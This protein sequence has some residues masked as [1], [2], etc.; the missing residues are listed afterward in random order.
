[1]GIP[2]F[3]SLFIRNIPGSVTEF[4]PDNLYGISIDCNGLIHR[5]AGEVFGYGRKSDGSNFSEHESLAINVLF[6]SN[7]SLLESKF[8]SRLDEALTQIF[9]ETIHVSTYLILSVDGVAP[10]AKI[11]QQR[12]RRFNSGKIRYESLKGSIPSKFDTAQITAGTPFMEKINLAITAWFHRNIPKLPKYSIYSSH[13]VPGEGEHK[14]FTILEKLKSL[15]PQETGITEEQFIDKNHCIY[16]LDA[17]LCFLTAMRPYNYYWIRESINLTVIR[18]IVVIQKVKDFIISRMSVETADLAYPIRYIYDFILLGFFIGDDFV[19]GMITLDLN[20]AITLLELQLQYKNFFTQEYQ[21]TRQQSFLIDYDSFGNFGQINWPLFSQ[22]ISSLDQIERNFFQEKV[23]NQKREATSSNYK[24]RNENHKN[25]NY[26]PSVFLELDYDN[27]LDN[28]IHIMTGPALTSVYE[29]LINQKQ[30]N[31]I[32]VY[33]NKILGIMK[34]YS[35]QDLDFIVP[36]YLTGLQWNI[37][38]YF[39]FKINN[40][41]YRNSLSPCIGHLIRYFRKNPQILPTIQSVVETYDQPKISSVV[42]LFSVLHPEYNAD[43][44]RQCKLPTYTY[45][46]AGLK[47]KD[48]TF[49]IYFPQEFLVIQEGKY[50]NQHTKVVVLSRL[51]LPKLLTIKSNV[52]IAEEMFFEGRLIKNTKENDSE[53]VESKVKFSENNPVKIIPSRPEKHIKPERND[54]YRGKGGAKIGGNMHGRES[55]GKFQP[56]NRSSTLLVQQNQFKKSS[57]EEFD[58]HELI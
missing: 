51:D 32:D 48:E 39:G 16:G 17:D 4:L 31:F 7:Y 53:K 57:N 47:L 14:I 12:T 13:L 27:F 40:W 58:E 24:S 23:N 50:D 55:R 54:T 15:I 19:N 35:D 30:A 33:R 20:I 52:K 9:I 42:Q 28:W 43:V 18:K 11:S 34:N 56:S 41:T 36:D 29:V 49:S 1:M 8:L 2:D 6:D 37:L 45:T 3:Y 10:F 44:I 38:Y 22:F 21:K 25:G 46:K 5:I 26:V